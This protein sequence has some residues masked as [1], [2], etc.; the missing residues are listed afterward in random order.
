MSIKLFNTLA[1]KLEI[2]KSLAP[3]QVGLY[4]CGPTVYAAL[5]LGNLR[6]YLFEDILRRAL[7]FNGYAVRH[8]VNITDVG[9][10]VSDADDGEDKME[11]GARR[12][13]LSAWDIAE[14]YTL[15]FKQDIAQLNILEPKIW[16]KAT[17]HIPEQ[18][19]L[20]Q[21]LIDK[22]YAYETSDGIYFDTTKLSDYGKLA[23][24]E[25]QRANPEQT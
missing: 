16:C 13:G 11:K 22:G 10:L 24:L 19:A 3:S 21:T 17:D 20:V 2:F 5:H 18:I 23:Q 6:T 14:Q 12:T 9:H 8:V 4:T 25:K 7:E 15:A 1:H